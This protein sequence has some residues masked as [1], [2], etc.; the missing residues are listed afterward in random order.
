M[1][2]KVVDPL[3]DGLWSLNRVYEALIDG[4]VDSFSGEFRNYSFIREQIVETEQSLQK[5]EQAANS[6]LKSLDENIEILTQDE[7]KL[8]REKRSTQQDLDNLKTEQES[9]N[10]LLKQSEHSVEVARSLLRSARDTLQKQEERKRNA[11]IVTGVGAGLLVIPVVGWIAGSA[12]VIGGAVELAEASKAVRVAEEEER[13]SESEVNQYRSRVSE[14]NSKISQ[15]K[16][17][18]SQKHDAIEQIR[19]KIQKLKEQRAAVAE[20]QSTV[21]KAV[22][23]LSILSGRVSAVECQ[24]RRFIH[25]EPVMKVMEDVMKAAGDIGG[26]QLLSDEDVPRLLNTM[27]ENNRKLAAI[28]NSSNNPE[29]E[30]YC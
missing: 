29:D 16:S 17:K 28:C 30:H 13:R 15:T 23:I 2:K 8:E 12:M 11:E 3:K 14:Y 4:D 27:R 24:T 10:K 18:I 19:K 20:F 1:V 6:G 25:L 21:R 5:S 7:G 26:N 22:R 9:N